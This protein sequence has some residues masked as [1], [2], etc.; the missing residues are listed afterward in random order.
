MQQVLARISE[1]VRLYVSRTKLL[2]E[3]RVNE[4]VASALL[5]FDRT[6]RKFKRRELA[7]WSS[8]T[9]ENVIRTL[10][11]F[12]RQGFLRKEREEVRLLD[13]KTLEGMASL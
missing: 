2:M 7:E 3:K 10:A 9:V 4:R 8:T 11:E 1:E 6:G 5:E 12:E 13:R